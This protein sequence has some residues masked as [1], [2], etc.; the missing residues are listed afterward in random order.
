MN[1]Q[2][3]QLNQINRFDYKLW[4]QFTEIAQPYW[5][6]LERG[7][8]RIFLVL[9]LLLLVFLF[10]F[11]FITVSGVTLISQQLFPT[12]MNQT[13]A[14]LVKNIQATLQSP[15]VYGVILA[16]VIPIAG[17]LLYR[18]KLRSRWQPWLLLAL[19][20]LLSL[21]VSGLNVI[22]SFVGRFFQTALAEKNQPVYWRFLFVY[23]GVFVVGTPI[24]VIYRYTQK[25]LGMY[26]REWL[27]GNFLDRYFGQR[28]YYEIDA[29]TQ[30]DNPDQ[31]VSEDVRSF[32]VV[33]LRYLLLILS[34]VIDLVAFTGILWSISQTLSFVLVGYA[35]FGT[36]VTILIG[37]RL[38]GLNFYQLKKEADFRYGMVHVRDN[39]ESIAFYRGEEQEKNQVS[40]RFREV[41]RNFNL[42]IGWERNLGFFTTSY[43]YFIVI[44][45]ALFVA[46]IYFA[47]KIDFGAI[48]QASFAFS[49]VLGA[50]S[51]IVNEFESLSPFIA[52]IKRLAALTEALDQPMTIVQPKGAPAINISEDSRLTLENV[53]LQTPNYQ[54]TLVRDLSLALAEDEQ[55][56]I[57]GQSGAGKSSL[58]RAIAGLWTSGTGRIVRPHLEDML[59]LPQRPYMILGSLRSQLLYPNTHHQVAD[60]ELHKILEQV[61]LADLP[62]RVG[63]FDIELDWADVLSLGEQQRLAFARLF[64]AQP[65]YAVLDEATSALDI[66]N[67]QRLYQHLQD[68]GTTYIS[69]GHRPSLLHYHQQ[70][71]ELE[72]EGRW[73]LL[74]V[75]DYSPQTSSF[76]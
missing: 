67:E 2:E 57:V 64:L 13:A 75:K 60:E 52:G 56:V 35:I 45:P 54:R 17:F 20:L 53:T 32:T 28:A 15:L 7:S 39:A 31:R 46:P 70:V 58:L 36:I 73:Q 69:V 27:T 22:I 61:N 71:L 74:P 8:G 66:K 43:D 51:I 30:I 3:P 4:Q 18:S 34:S 59:F 19:L 62:E 41:I 24:V 48:S 29:T 14:G 76:A 44:L 5:Y 47:G 42:L 26:W 65:R 40:Q 38:F 72:G 21:S 11:L 23:A 16:T 49:Q 6:P 9:L 37:K 33:S 10:A 68:A 55:L 50:L 63:G 1:P 12:F 25:K